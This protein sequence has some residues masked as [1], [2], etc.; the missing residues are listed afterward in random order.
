MQ[1]WDL[2]KVTFSRAENCIDLKVAI[3]TAEL[4]FPILFLSITHW[5][6]ISIAKTQ[7]QADT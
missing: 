6:S 2:A 7:W 1:K 5:E 4:R 3:S